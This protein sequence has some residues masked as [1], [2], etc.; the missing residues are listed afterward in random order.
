MIN[1]QEEDWFIPGVKEYK[2]SI[3][4]SAKQ[5]AV[6]IDGE[7]AFFLG[8]NKEIADKLVNATN[9][10][11]C[12]QVNNLFCVSFIY[13]GL[14]D[15]ILCNEMTQ[16]GLLS[17]PSF[18]YVD[19]EFQKYAEIAEPGWLYQDEQFIVPGVYE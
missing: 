11:E 17:F 13:D 5:L 12:D 10:L 18:V 4:E 9:F 7:I 1:L 2:L 16:A 8:V 14:I 6:V 3:G 15:Q 19:K